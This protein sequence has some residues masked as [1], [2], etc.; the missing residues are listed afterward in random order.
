MSQGQRKKI[1]I[2]SSSCSICNETVERLNV[3]WARTMILKFTTCTRDLS[4]REQSS[5][6]SKACR[7]S[8][9]TASSRIAVPGVDLTKKFSGRRSAER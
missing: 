8:S 9:W 3:L 1:E 7:V 4:R 5:M 6:A 2:F